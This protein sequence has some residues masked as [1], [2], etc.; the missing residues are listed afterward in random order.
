MTQA[1]SVVRLGLLLVA[2]LVAINATGDG[3]DDPF[4]GSNGT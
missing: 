3:V 1:K 4:F 2:S